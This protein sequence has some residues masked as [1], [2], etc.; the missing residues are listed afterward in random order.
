L[1]TISGWAIFTEG[2]TAQG[3]L[4]ALKEQ[5]LLEWAD[6]QNWL[7]EVSKDSSEKLADEIV[8]ALHPV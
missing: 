4:D 1:R 5:L 3:S 8:K 6:I 7:L 2:A